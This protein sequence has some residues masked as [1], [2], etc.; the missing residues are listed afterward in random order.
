MR[1][2]SIHRADN[3]DGTID[4]TRTVYFGKSP[5]P[6]IKRAYTRVLQAHIATAT[7]IFPEGTSADWLNMLAKKPL[8]EYVHSQS[9]D[10]PLQDSRLT[11]R[12]GLDFQHG[13]GHGVGCYLSVHECKSPS[14]LGTDDQ[15]QYH[16]LMVTPSLREW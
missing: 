14:L 15:I 1:S 12:D 9:H 10:T 5:S 8:F 11:N 16:S 6:E 13:L 2:T 7:S 3:P 4:T